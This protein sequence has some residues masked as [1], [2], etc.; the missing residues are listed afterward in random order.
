MK[1]F[2][3]LP[4]EVGLQAHDTPQSRVRV[5]HVFQSVVVT[6]QGQARHPQDQDMPEVHP[7]SAGRLLATRD[8]LLQ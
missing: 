6:I 2:A 5:D 3:K 1:A 4:T 8:P 7:G